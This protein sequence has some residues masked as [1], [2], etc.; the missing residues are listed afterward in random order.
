LTEEGNHAIRKSRKIVIDRITKAGF[1]QNIVMTRWGEPR[2]SLGMSLDTLKR[3][4]EFDETPL[5]G[6]ED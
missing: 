4:P 2:V 5:A 6:H 1:G 3:E